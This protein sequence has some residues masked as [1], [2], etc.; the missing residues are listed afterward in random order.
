MRSDAA[1]KRGTEFNVPAMRVDEMLKRDDVEIV[2]NLTVPLA[3]TDVSL[4][5]LKAG[6]HVYSEK[7]LGVECRGSAQG[8]GPRQ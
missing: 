6:K 3:H 7:P 2:I 8:D 4:A 1:A 5:V